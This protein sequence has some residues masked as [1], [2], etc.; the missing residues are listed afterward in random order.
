VNASGFGVAIV[1]GF[2]DAIVF[3]FGVAIVFDFGDVSGFD[4][5][6]G[7]GGAASSGMDAT[8]SDAGGA[9]SGESSHAAGVVQSISP[10]SI[11]TSR[12]L[13]LIASLTYF[14]EAYGAWT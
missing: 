3:G 6:F 13:S 1:S 2:G 11:S 12:S 10:R 14:V 4:D 7:F 5:G 9:G 8:V